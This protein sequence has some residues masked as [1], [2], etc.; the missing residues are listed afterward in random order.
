[1]RRAN[2]ANINI[3]LE[4]RR[5]IDRMIK[6]KNISL[7][8]DCLKKMKPLVEKHDGNFSS[9]MRE[10]INGLE[11]SNL[12]K[13]ASTVDES[14]LNWIL[15]EIDGRLIPEDVLNR[16]IDPLVINNFNNLDRHINDKFRAFEWKVN[17]D[18]KCDNT[19][20]PSQIMLDIC[21]EYKKIKFV[22]CMVSQ[23]IVKNSPE[24]SPF[25]IKSVTN[26]NNNIKVE[27]YRCRNKKEADSSLIA[28]FGIFE[29]IAQAMK[30]NSYFWKCIVNRHVSSNYQMVTIHRNYFEDILSGKTPMGEIMIESIAKKPIQDIPLKDLLGLIKQVY[31]ISK[32][33]EEVEIRN[34]KII[35]SHNYRNKEAIEHIK[36]QVIMLLENNGH[37]Y[38]AKIT[39]NML[40]FEHRPDI[41]IKINEI[42]NNLKSDNQLD[43]EL[44]MFLSFLR[45]LKQIP[46]TP[47]SITVLGR[48]IGTNLMREYGKDNNIKEWNL[49][50]FQKAFEMIDYKIHRE[51][52]WKFDGKN[53]LY[54]IRKCNI[55]M[56]GD[57][58]DTYKCR[59][60]REAFKGALEYAFGN[61]AEL[62]IKKLL[63][64]GDN[65]C[66]V[67]I[68]IKDAI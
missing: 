5:N 50:I 36:K 55:S 8:E 64:H 26:L 32:V 58:F 20:N 68:K 2:I 27:L 37:L 9:A 31:E 40:I 51:S 61:R 54:R 42:V 4:D 48:R 66:E 65:I 57:N 16:I 49:D 1:M 29:E 28:F 47:M 59:T 38:D 22:T 6:T 17:I 53:L 34:D 13:E 63:T 3:I 14:M 30:S 39:T 41:G 25:A 10:I 23:Y 44:I 33:V 62:D 56:E 43:Q 21:G 52:E 24:R 35:L 15:E 12:S 45:G 11:K 67:S 18:I 46:D 60:A 7:D 19:I